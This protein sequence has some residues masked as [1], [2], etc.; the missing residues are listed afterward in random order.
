MT[1]PRSIPTVLALCLLS[2]FN[3]CD[4][5]GNR[6]RARE[7]RQIKVPH[8][9]GAGLSVVGRNGSITVI[10]GAA[11]PDVRITAKLVVTGETQDKADN[12]L[13]ETEIKCQRDNDRRLVVKV[14]FPDQAASGDGV[15]FEIEVPSVDGVSLKSSN[16][17]IFTKGLAGKADYRTSN[18]EVTV[19]GHRGDLVVDTSNG[20]VK[21]EDATGSVSV[22][23]SNGSV[24]VHMIADGVLKVDASNAN[25]TVSVGA[26]FGGAMTLDTSNGRVQVK[27][28]DGLLESKN[29]NKRSGKLVFSKRGAASKIDISNGS[30]TVRVRGQ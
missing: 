10:G 30:I 20:N 15:S 28:P 18:G 16:G 22:D 9:E 3:A 19:R 2:G 29:L 24:D 23:S 6:F 12:R 14:V 17:V 13:A 8:I 26:L 1:L 4:I 5:T 27:D 25:V 11:G 7:T 21:I